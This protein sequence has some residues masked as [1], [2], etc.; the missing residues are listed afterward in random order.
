LVLQTCDPR[1]AG[2]TPAG[3]LHGQEYAEGVLPP[4]GS[5]AIPNCIQDA[6]RQ[7]ARILASVVMKTAQKRQVKIVLFAI[8]TKWLAIATKNRSPA[9][10]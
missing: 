7:T 1:Q 2:S 9:E 6:K 3:Y 8:A 10:E 4:P 5:M